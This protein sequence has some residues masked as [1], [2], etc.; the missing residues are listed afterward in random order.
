[1]ENMLNSHEIPIGF[2]IALAM[3][4]DAM[5]Y[6]SS[7]SEEGQQQVIE[8]THTINSKNEMQA[9]VQSLGQDSPA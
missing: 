9:Y 2:G 1:M 7:L 4:P 5:R 6:Y 8:H 3:F